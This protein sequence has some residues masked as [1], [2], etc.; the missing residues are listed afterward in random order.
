MAIQVTA[1][2]D[3][4]IKPAFEDIC[5]KVGL[6]VSSAFN[7]FAHAVVNEGGIPFKLQTSETLTEWQFNNEA[8]L[9]KR[10][11]ALKEGKGIMFSN[12]EELEQ[13]LENR[14]LR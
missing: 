11:N 4:D 8:E 10:A 13:Y 7:V 9:L 2:I 6:S 14:R 1:R 12:E 5:A 3:D